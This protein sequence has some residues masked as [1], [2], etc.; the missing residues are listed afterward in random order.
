MVSPTSEHFLYSFSTQEDSEIC[1]FLFAPYH[2][3][4]VWV[5]IGVIDEG[6]SARTMGLS[7][8]SSLSVIFGCV[9]C[10][11]SISVVTGSSTTDPSS[12]TIIVDHKLVDGLSRALSEF[13]L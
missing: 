9:Y 5:R 3:D 11:D 2:V 12:S 6:S 1:A 7:V 10:R 13:F 4:N 8:F